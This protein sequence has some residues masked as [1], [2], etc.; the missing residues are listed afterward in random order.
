M[1]DKTATNALTAPRKQIIRQSPGGLAHVDALLVARGVN[2]TKLRVGKKRKP[3][4]ARKGS[5]G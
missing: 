1:Q 3:D 5:C 2:Q 4:F